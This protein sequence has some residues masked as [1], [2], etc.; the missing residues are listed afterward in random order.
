MGEEEDLVP[1]HRWAAVRAVIRGDDSAARKHI[2]AV[3]VVA[4]RSGWDR[5]MTRA[6]ATRR[7][8]VGQPE[9]AAARVNPSSGLARRIFER[10]RYTC[11]Y[12]GRRTID[13]AVLKELSRAFPDLFPYHPHWKFDDSHRL[14]WTHSASIEHAVPVSRGGSSEI[15]NLITTCY[16]CNAAK[17]DALAEELGWHQ[18]PPAESDWD[19]LIQDLP[20]LVAA[21]AELPVP[22][23]A[24]A[25][26]RAEPPASADPASTKPPDPGTASEEPVTYHR[27]EAGFAAWKR[28]NAGGVILSGS[29]RKPHITS[30]THIADDFDPPRPWTNTRKGLLQD[31]A[32]A[33]HLGKGA[34][35]RPGNLPDVRLVTS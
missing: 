34:R 13:L 31:P 29:S 15:E 26:A 35:N 12:C 6:K 10:D 30:C 2:A 19:G 16:E 24:P 4:L 32:A 21:V 5:A 9:A 27:D 11:R 1:D 22:P 20:A 23:P 7:R 3:D 25:R 18:L 14:Y 17:G 33:P 28:E 8:T